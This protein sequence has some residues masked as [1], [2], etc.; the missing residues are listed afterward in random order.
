[1]NELVLSVYRILGR[2]AQRIGFRLPYPVGLAM[3]KIVDL[4]AAVTG[5]RFPISAIRVKK[6]A[7]DSV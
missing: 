6:F 5:T 2:P 4:V 1:M 3:G 7:F